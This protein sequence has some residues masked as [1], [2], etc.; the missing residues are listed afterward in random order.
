MPAEPEVSLTSLAAARRPPAARP[1]LSNPADGR[2]PDCQSS[3]C[4]AIGGTHSTAVSIRSST[5]LYAPHHT[6]PCLCGRQSAAADQICRV[7]IGRRALYLR[8]QRATGS[9]PNTRLT[10]ARSRCVSR[11]SR[12]ILA[13]ARPPIPPSSAHPSRRAN[14]PCEG[15]EC[16]LIRPL[17]DNVLSICPRCRRSSRNECSASRFG[18]RRAAPNIVHH[19]LC[20]AHARVTILSLASRWKLPIDTEPS[21]RPRTAAALASALIRA[22]PAP[23]LSAPACEHHHLAPPRPKQNLN[24]HVLRLPVET[25]SSRNQLLIHLLRG[26]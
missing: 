26:M 11:H 10:I 14:P 3:N 25:Q 20:P 2:R 9:P 15:G 18:R 16:S 21:L 7:L 12:T 13:P 5:V 23:D 22:P 6:R 24:G 4:R 8:R 17:Q 1:M 19:V